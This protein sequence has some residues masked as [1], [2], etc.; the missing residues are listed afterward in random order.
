MRAAFVFIYWN[1]V[2]AVRKVGEDQ[3]QGKKN[4]EYLEGRI[5]NIR[6]RIFGTLRGH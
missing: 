2:K 6:K 1:N 5:Y 3:H 4:L